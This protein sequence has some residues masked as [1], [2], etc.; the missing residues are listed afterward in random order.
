[1]HW[2]DDYQFGEKGV[3]FKD[4]GGPWQ[5]VGKLG[6]SYQLSSLWQFGYAYV[7][8]SNGNLYDKNPSFNGHSLFAKYQF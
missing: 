6:A 8:M 7:H 5:F 3:A 2:Q 4:Y 1:M